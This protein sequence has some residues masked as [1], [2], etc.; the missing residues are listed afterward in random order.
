MRIAEGL[1]CAILAAA[2]AGPAGAADESVL[3][4]PELLQEAPATWILTGGG[5]IDGNGGHLVDGSA[6]YAPNDR[7]TFSLHAG[8]SDTSTR[9]DSLT[10]SVAGLDFDRRFEHWGLGLSG[11]YWEDPSLA[12]TTTFGG[13]V[14]AKFG[15]WRLTALAETRASDFDSFTVSGTIDRPNLPPI[16]VSGDANCDLDGIGIGARFSYTGERWNAYLSGK[17]Y[18][19][20]KF[21]CRFASLTIGRVHVSPQRLRTLSPLFLRLLTLRASVAGY[22]NLR[23]DTVFLDSSLA[24]GISAIRGPRTYALDYSHTRELFDGLESNALTAS[25]TFALSRRTDLELH[26]GAFDSDEASTLG[27]AGVMLIAYFGG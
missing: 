27:F 8:Y 10:A 6:A 16:T 4:D 12:R 24:A 5:E 11:G 23:E 14:F 7:T 26:V 3:D 13:S 15:E 22:I 25:L 9:T 19:Y 20:E 2:L 18:D 1:V 21:N 17:S